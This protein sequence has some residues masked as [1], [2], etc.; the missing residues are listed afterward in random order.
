MKKWMYVRTNGYDMIVKID[1]E[2]ARVITE[3]EDFPKSD[4]LVES[5]MADVIDADNSDS[6]EEYPADAILAEIDASDEIVYEAE[7]DRD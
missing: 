5:F 3:T 7:I 2:T 6:W 1:G 4:D